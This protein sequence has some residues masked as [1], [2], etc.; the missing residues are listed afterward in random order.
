V[1]PLPDVHGGIQHLQIARPVVV[2]VPSRV[3][4]R[5]QHTRGEVVCA[6]FGKIPVVK[7]EN[8]DAA[9]H[10]LLLIVLHFVYERRMIDGCQRLPVVSG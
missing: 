10:Q 6:W 7:R 2:Q 9:L 5:H 4:R 8:C 1:F 3:H